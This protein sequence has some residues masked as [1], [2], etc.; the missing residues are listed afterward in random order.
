MTPPKFI[1]IHTDEGF[2]RFCILWI[3]VIEC[4]TT[5]FLHTHSWLSW[6]DENID[7]DEV[8]LKE[9][10]EDARYIKKITTKRDLK[11]HECGQTK[12]NGLE[13]STFLNYMKSWLK[14]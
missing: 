14:V 10:L 4:F 3:L 5:T 13:I 9:K 11:H 1:Y 7:D 6:V 2:E 8:G 12:H